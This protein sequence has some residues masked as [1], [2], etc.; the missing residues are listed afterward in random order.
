MWI[1]N[2][3]EL[4]EPSF[5]VLSSDASSAAKRDIHVVLRSGFNQCG[6]S[7]TVLVFSRVWGWHVQHF[8]QL[9]PASLLSYTGFLWVLEQASDMI[10]LATAMK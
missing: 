10:D 7:W 6:V 9:V 5:I 3:A 4:L 1:C 8:V 2:D